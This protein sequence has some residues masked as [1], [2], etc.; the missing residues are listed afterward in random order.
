MADN[1]AKAVEIKPDLDKY[2]NGIS[3]SGK[4]PSRSQRMPISQGRSTPSITGVKECMKIKDGGRPLATSAS[5][6]RATAA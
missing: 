4:R 5:I 3:G 6:I 2:V 1:E